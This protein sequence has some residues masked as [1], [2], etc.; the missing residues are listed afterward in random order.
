MAAEV[1]S[2]VLPPAPGWARKVPRDERIFLWFV[3]AS[4]AF[5]S[6]FT[7]AWLFLGGQNVPTDS[8]R[9]T[10]EAFTRQVQAFVQRYGREDGKVVVPPGEDAY[11]LAARYQFYPELVLRAGE[12]Y[13][14]WVSSADALHGFSIV[15]GHQ[16]INLEIAPQHAYGATFTPEEPGEYL[17]VCN[18]YCGLGH[19]A[20]KGRIVVEEG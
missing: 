9:A 16:N 10:P 12:E 19:H 7:I 14:I 13:R 3:G 20:M 11:V 1:E 17:I 18:E 8:Y 2:S 15:G 4:V 5:M 6:A